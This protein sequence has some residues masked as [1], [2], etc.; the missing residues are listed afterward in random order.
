[1]LLNHSFVL[2]S[3][4]PI[5]ID[6]NTQVMPF[7]VCHGVATENVVS[8]PFGLVDI[9][10]SEDAYLF[11]VALP[12]LRKNECKIKC[13]ILSNGT[14]NVRGEV[15]PGLQRESVGGFQT[16]VEQYSS[17]GPFTVSFQLPGETDP[18]LFSPNFRVDGIFE[19]VILKPR[20]PIV[21]PDGSPN[22]NIPDIIIEDGG[23]P[24]PSPE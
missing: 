3:M 18:R 1:M 4:D 23:P 15:V 6:G 17:P 22:H 12:G 9:G 10:E 14:I 19:G 24:P 5:N 20:V 8:P 21:N 2:G 11:R 16:R 7:M 13:E